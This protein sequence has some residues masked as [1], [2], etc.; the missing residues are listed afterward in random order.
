[1]KTVIAVEHNLLY[2]AQVATRLR[3]N[4]EK[5]RGRFILCKFGRK[6]HASLFHDRDERPFKSKGFGQDGR[7]GHNSRY[8]VAI[9]A[10]SLSEM[11]AL[12]KDE[13]GEIKFVPSV[14]KYY[15]RRK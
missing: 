3:R 6:G 8:E 11:V 2:A 7:I 1:M 4:P 14:E 10:R 9:M 5:I 15:L 12:L 13:F